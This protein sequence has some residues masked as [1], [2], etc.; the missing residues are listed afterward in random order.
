MAILTSNATNGAHSGHTNGNSKPNSPA[1]LDAEKLIVNLVDK[2][3]PIPAPET[4]VF[5]E[6]KTD[7]MLVVHFDPV[8]GW[9]VPE[10]K[11]YGPL[12]IDPSSSCLQYCPNVFEGMK[13]YIG[14]DGEARLFRPEKNMQRLARSAAR[15]AL[16]KFDQDVLLTLIKRLIL[17]DKRW[18]P[19]KPGYSLYIRP[20]I[21][22]TR[23]SLGV[24]HS[25]TATL[26]V[27]LSP[28]GPYFKNGLHPISL[29]AVSNTVRAWPG[30]T[31]SHKLGLNY[32]P[33]FMP[34]I[35]AASKGYDQILWLLETDCQNGENGKELRITEVGAMNVFVVVKRD[36]TH[37]DLIT[38]PLDGTIL[39][40]VTRASTLALA[41][42]HTSGNVTLPGVPSALKIYTHEQPLTMSQL[43]S[44]HS[45][46]KIV[47]FFGVGTAAIIAPVDR[48]GW[49]GGDLLFTQ[50]SK[51]GLGLIGRG[52]FELITSIQTGRTKFED[53][54]VSCE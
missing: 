44:L 20:T 23:S 31:G 35:D 46:G 10:I 54:S 33:A 45:E 29:L 14:L 13:A 11:P 2:P 1:E 22:G 34:Q 15:V 8:N 32:A 48:I 53:W 27:I 36:D 39:P 40:G 51:D 52:V 26:F 47:E 17:V 9:T 38:P 50:E 5:G 21:I 37:L 24:R 18:I 6:T 25:D 30:G 16:P 41:D 7:H 12:S 19:T 42:A 4:L 3:K 49:N 43:S 28:T